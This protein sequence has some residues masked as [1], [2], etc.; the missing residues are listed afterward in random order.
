V[1]IGLREE[2]VVGLCLAASGAGVLPARAWPLDAAFQRL[3]GQLSPDSS[4]AAAVAGMAPSRGRRGTG[5]TERLLR[6]LAEAGRV[7]QHGTGPA[8]AWAFE[9]EWAAGWGE[10][11][12]GLGTKD[13]AAFYEAGQVLA[14]CVSTWRSALSRTS[15]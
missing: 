12:G 14:S 10:L 15:V 6:L 7:R 5:E 2:A 13:R 3:A 1:G 11:L 9:A 8:A 4:Y